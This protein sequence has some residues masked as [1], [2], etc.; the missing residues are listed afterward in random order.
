R[1]R[2]SSP[3]RT[4]SHSIV[5]HTLRGGLTM[6][7]AIRRFSPALLLIASILSSCTHSNLTAD[8]AKNLVLDSSVYIE[9][10]RFFEGLERTVE[11]SEWE[12]PA[13]TKRWMVTTGTLATEPGFSPWLIDRNH[14]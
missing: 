7:R 10:E 6:K 9:S 3:R 2:S 8:E 14:F 1:P 13:G 4:L 5:C 11:V 12:C